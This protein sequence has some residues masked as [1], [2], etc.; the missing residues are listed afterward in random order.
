MP[1]KKACLEAMVAPRAF[2]DEEGNL[3]QGCGVSD[4]F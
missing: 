2:Q 3:D 1:N 4:S